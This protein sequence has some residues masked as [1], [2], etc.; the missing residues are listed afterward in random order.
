[1]GGKKKILI[2]VLVLV[3][4]VLGVFLIFKFFFANGVSVTLPG[5]KVKLVYWGL[6]ETAE[7]MEPLISE[8]EKENKNV[9]IEY[10][11]Q[12][13]TEY[14]ERLTNA[15]GQGKGPDIFRFHNSWTVMLRDDLVSVPDEVYTN[16]EFEKT[17]YPAIV[18]SL[19][20]GGKFY[21]V[22]LMVD[23][24]ALYYNEDLL[25]SAGLTPP[26]SWDDFRTAATKLTVRDTNGRIQTAGAALGTTGNVDFWSDILGLMMLQS[27]V[28]FK[29]IDNSISADGRDLG[30]EALSYYTQ[31]YRVDRVWDETMPSSISAFASGRVAMIMGPSWIANEIRAQNA[32][33]SFKIVPVPQLSDAEVNWATF[34]VEGVS[35]KSKNQKKAWEFLKFLSSKESLRKYYNEAVQGEGRIYGEPYSR[36]DMKSELAGDSMVSVFLNQAETAKTWYLAGKTGDNGINDQMIKY[37]ED[38]INSINGGGDVFSA[39]KTASLGVSQVLGQYGLQ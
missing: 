8:F 13:L 9:E 7:V 26:T 18:D 1:M 29:Q 30:Q 35:V 32:N 22:S 17:F 25:L 16:D 37:F 31:Y 36:R 4:V 21:G 20:M 5:G 23:N 34:W 6:W 38:A 24:I 12:N 3:G 11:K 14:R 10:I 15:I 39:L 33:L 2:I 27:G 28:N 19:K